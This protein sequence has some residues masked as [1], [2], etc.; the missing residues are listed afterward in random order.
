MCLD[1]VMGVCEENFLDRLV[2]SS[3]YGVCLSACIQYRWYFVILEE[4][5]HLGIFI[6]IVL[7]K[8]SKNIVLKNV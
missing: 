6:K 2:E 1:T 3:M 8:E 7:F 4:K 5:A